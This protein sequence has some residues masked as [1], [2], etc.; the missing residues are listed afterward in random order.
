M[1][2]IRCIGSVFEVAEPEIVGEIDDRSLGADL[3][4]ESS[5]GSSACVAY[6]I[7]CEIRMAMLSKVTTKFID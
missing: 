2:L 5:A 7:K 1:G 4:A 3:G 6:S